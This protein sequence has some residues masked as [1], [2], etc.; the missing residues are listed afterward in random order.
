[1]IGAGSLGMGS[2]QAC[3]FSGLGLVM[4]DPDEAAGAGGLATVPASLH[5][6]IKKDKLGAG[7]RALRTKMVA[8][9]WLGRRTGRGVYRC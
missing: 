4:I 2:A 6:L 1:M 7:H 8:A 3:A 9:G 5:R